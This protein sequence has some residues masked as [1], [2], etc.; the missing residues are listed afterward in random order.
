MTNISIIII[1]FQLDGQEMVIENVMTLLGDDDHRVRQAAV[2]IICRYVGAVLQNNLIII[3]AEVAML[4]LWLAKIY[5]NGSNIC[6]CRII[7]QLFYASDELQCCP[8]VALAAQMMLRYIPGSSKDSPSR[9]GKRS[10]MVSCHEMES[11]LSRIITRIMRCFSQSSNKN[12]TVS[13][14]AKS[15]FIINNKTL[16]SNNFYEFIGKWFGFFNLNKSQIVL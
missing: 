5:G 9:C 8:L 1:C 16:L 12:F 11:A 15:L 3:N 7:P 4:L 2:N 14:F 6:V 10:G 13:A